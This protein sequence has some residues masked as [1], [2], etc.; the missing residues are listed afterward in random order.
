MCQTRISQEVNWSECSVGTMLW[1]DWGKL[2]YSRWFFNHCHLRCIWRVL[3]EEL[4]MRISERTVWSA[5]GSV[6]KAVPSQG[7]N[8]GLNQVCRWDF[9][10]QKETARRQHCREVC[11]RFCLPLINFLGMFFTVLIHTFG[12]FLASNVVMWI[13]RLSWF[14][15]GDVQC[16][17]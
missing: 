9:L 8:P 4:Y 13:Q 6:L 17:R 14:L 2:E 1:K 16:S 11:S 10:S 5:S 3:S 7:I 15:R 12:Y